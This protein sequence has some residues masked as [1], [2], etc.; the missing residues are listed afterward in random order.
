VP[1]AVIVIRLMS[2]NWKG[3]LTGSATVSEAMSTYRASVCATTSA[4]R[5]FPLAMKWR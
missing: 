2:L 4:V 5:G 3:S 1:Q